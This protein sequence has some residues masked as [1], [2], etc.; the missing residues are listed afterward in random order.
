MEKVS[1]YQ[2][3][4]DAEKVGLLT[5]SIN[6]AIEKERNRYLAEYELTAVQADVIRFLSYARTKEI[7]VNQV[8]IERELHLSTPTVTG[9]LK[10]LELKGFIVKKESQKDHRYKSICMTERTI[11]VHKKS[12]HIKERIEEYLMQGL[13]QAERDQAIAA[14]EVMLENMQTLNDTTFDD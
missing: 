5:K 12:A 1:G 13:S 9:I 6:L 14:L 11:R 10:R 7:E 4:T 3:M 8:D 2:N